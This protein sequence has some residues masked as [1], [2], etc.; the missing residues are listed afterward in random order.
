MAHFRFSRAKRVL[1]LL[2][3]PGLLACRAFV[4][5]PTWPSAPTRRESLALGLGLGLA[6]ASAWA[7]G[8]AAA[9]IR[10]CEKEAKEILGDLSS[11]AAVPLAMTPAQ[12]SE[13]QDRGPPTMGSFQSLEGKCSPSALRTAAEALAKAPPKGL[14]RQEAEKLADAPKRIVEAREAIVEA[15]ARKQGPRLYGAVKKYLE[16]TQALLI[17]A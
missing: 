12:V 16:A 5:A 13:V 14:N 11:S 15:N 2:L 7:D 4:T 1:P 6:P 17:G 9:K 10:E 8:A 3:L